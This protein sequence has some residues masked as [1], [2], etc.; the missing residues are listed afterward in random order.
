MS[1]VADNQVEIC[2]ENFLS[3]GNFV[4]RLIGRKNNRHAEIFATREINCGRNF[5]GVG[6]R[7]QRQINFANF[8][9]VFFHG[10]FVGTNADSIERLVGIS[11]PL[12]ER[13]FDE[14][15]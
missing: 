12:D 1:F 11:C 13:L 2:A 14:R 5:V 9:V 8:V 7:R 15:N 4:E 3:F 6:G 10:G